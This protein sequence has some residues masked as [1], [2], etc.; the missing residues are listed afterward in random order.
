MSIRLIIFD[1]DGTLVDSIEDITT[2][3]NWALSSFGVEGFEPREVAGMVGEGALKLVQR[4]FERRNVNFD[5]KLLNERFTQY[6]AGHVAEKSK[7]YPGVK[8]VLEALSGCEKIIVSNKSE[9]LSRLTLAALGLEHHFRALICADT[10]PERK[11]L[12]GPILHA[13]KLSGMSRE[14]TI[15]VGDSEMDVKAGNAA[16]VKTVAVTYG[17]GRE[18][19]HEEADFVIDTISGLPAIIDCLNNNGE[20]IMN[21]NCTCSIV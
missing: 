21:G 5:M 13:M 10:I 11:P 15:V 18:G 12:P 4:A 17:Y 16:C 9:M 3:L 2:A 6:Y 8:D 20:G 7:V 19:F 1:L 14:E